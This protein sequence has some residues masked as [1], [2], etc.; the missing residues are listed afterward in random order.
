MGSRRGMVFCGIGSFWCGAYFLGGCLGFFG[1]SGFR[2]G[3]LEG[4]CFQ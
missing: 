3:C 1:M 2:F 4:R